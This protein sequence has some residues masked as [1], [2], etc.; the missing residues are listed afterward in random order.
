VLKGAALSRTIYP[1][2]F[3]RHGSDIDIM[4]RSGDVRQ[5]RKNPGSQRIQMQLPVL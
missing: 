4:V 1:D 3:L 2:P 5:A